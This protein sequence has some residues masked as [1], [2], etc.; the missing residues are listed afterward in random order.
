MSEIFAVQLT[1]V[2]TAGLAVFAIVTA[3][4]ARRAFLKQSQEVTAIEQQVKDAQELTQQ[5]AEL[6]RVQFE[7]LELQRQQLEDQRA[8]S[9]RQAEVLDLQADELR[10]SLEERKREA[11]QQRRAQA[12]MVFLKQDNFAGRTGA[13]GV[14]APPNARLTVV[15]SSDQPV[16]DAE[17]YW[18]RGSAGWGEPNPEPLGMI[19]PGGDPSRIRNFPEG[20]NMAV[21]GAIL[22]FTDAAGVKWVRRPDGYLGEQV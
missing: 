11:E 10:E 16:Y 13:P 1:A 4:Y 19:L 12:A 18:R 8:A 20:T 15:N 9:A 6:L 17:L 22:R 14:A 3:W 7:Q 5:Q 21:S 2:A